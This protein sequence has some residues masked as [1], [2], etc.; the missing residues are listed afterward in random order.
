MKMTDEDTAEKLEQYKT[1]SRRKSIFSPRAS[2]FFIGRIAAKHTSCRGLF[3]LS[4]VS[5][6]RVDRYINSK[7]ERVVTTGNYDVPN[8][9]ISLVCTDYGTKPS[10][11]RSSVINKYRLQGKGLSRNGRYL[12][13]PNNR[14][15]KVLQKTVKDITAY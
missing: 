9:K 7:Q 10:S 8:N 3:S 1:I 14:I 5:A 13:K 12:K 15:V 11:V 6:L 2:S 4:G